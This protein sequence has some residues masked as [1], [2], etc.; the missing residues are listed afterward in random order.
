MLCSKREMKALEAP[1]MNSI[2]VSSVF[3]T[4]FEH[5]QSSVQHSIIAYTA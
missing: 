3:V 2:N 5:I 1:E 4:N